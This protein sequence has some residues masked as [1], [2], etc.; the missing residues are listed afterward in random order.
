MTFAI[1]QVPGG[2][3]TEDFLKDPLRDCCLEYFSL[4]LLLCSVHCTLY[5]A[6]VSVA[7]GVAV[8]Y[9]AIPM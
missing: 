6:N 7:V 2:G 8:H 9:A 1:F 4:L 5:S 3:L